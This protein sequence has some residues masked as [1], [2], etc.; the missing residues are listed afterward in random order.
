VAGDVAAFIH[1]LRFDDL[2]DA[3]RERACS[4]LLDL[5]GVAAAGTT[6]ELSRIIRGFA[7]AQ[8]AAGDGRGARLL[9]DGRRVSPAGAALAGAATSDA[10][11]AHDGHV[12]T[13]GHAGVAVLPA[14]LAFAD[15]KGGI[16]GSE[17]LTC[18][19]LGYEIATRAGIALHASA[20]D[21]HTSGAWNA[22]GCAA[23]GARL[24]GLDHE[25]SRHALGIA[26]YWGPRSPMMRCI[27]HPSMLKDGSAWGALAGVSAAHLA[28]AGFSGAPA[29]T[30]DGEALSEIWADLGIRWRI[31]EQYMK[32]Y[33]VC[34]W[35]QPAVEAAAGLKAAFNIDAQDIEIV[36]VTS[37]HAAVRLAA[38]EPATTE[39]AQYSLPFPV[40]AALVRGKLGAEEIGESGLRD[41]AIRALS[42]AMVLGES[43]DYNA[44]FPAERW[45]HVTFV[46]KDGRR[47]VSEPA[48]ARGGPETPLADGEIRAKYV[49]LA[50]ALLEPARI[51]RIERRIATLGT[52]STHDLLDDLL[53]PARVRSFERENAASCRPSTT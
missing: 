24:L 41:P 22:L 16:D 4:L 23:L 34:R 39:A 48:E 7:A 2:P 25:K 46:M 38:R 13:K 32:P 52:G 15:A 1:D 49:A 20:A 8:M 19:V 43:E 45:A 6:T 10:F 53:A 21:Y 5:I 3:V 30:V 44:R 14:I 42:A 51:E 35:A 18:L 27:D 37:F 36:E 33:P 29:E 9:F 40:A 28:A 11:D 50:G 47:L 12:L 31:L 26:E 17:L